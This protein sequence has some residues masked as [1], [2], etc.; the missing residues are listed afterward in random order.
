VLVL[1]N[2]VKT[3]PLSLF[4]PLLLLLPSLSGLPWMVIAKKRE[5]GWLV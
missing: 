2:F 3:L 1:E 4:F 5:K